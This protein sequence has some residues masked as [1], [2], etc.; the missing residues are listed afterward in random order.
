MFDMQIT[1]A[2]RATIKRSK[3]LFPFFLIVSPKIITALRKESSKTIKHITSL[4]FDVMIKSIKPIIYSDFVTTIESGKQAYLSSEE[5]T[6]IQQV[7]WL[8]S[9][10]SQAFSRRAQ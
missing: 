9:I 2:S 10:F 3:F 4:N 5:L 6:K 8:S 1:S 7:S